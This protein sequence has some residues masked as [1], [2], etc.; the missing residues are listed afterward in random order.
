ML[1]LRRQRREGE[2]LGY[3]YGERGRATRGKNV[4][5]NLLASATELLSARQASAAGFRR[6]WPTVKTARKTP[7]LPKT[8]YEGPLVVP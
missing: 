3:A 8:P 6:V 5:Q 7:I 2:M 4:Y 1:L